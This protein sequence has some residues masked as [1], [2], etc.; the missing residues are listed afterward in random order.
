MFGKVWRQEYVILYDDSSLIWFRD[1]D[2]TTSPASGGHQDSSPPE[3]AVVLRECP[4][5]IA[6]GQVRDVKAARMNK[7]LLL[8]QAFFWPFGR[9]RWGME[10]PK[11]ELC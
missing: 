1:N 10:F 3:G 9:Q 2:K 5:M 6:A 7:Y 11:I 8:A 4:E